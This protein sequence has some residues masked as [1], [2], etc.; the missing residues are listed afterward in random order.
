M[1]PSQR[2]PL[3][4]DAKGSSY[5]CPPYKGKSSG[6]R[7]KDISK[8]SSNSGK[9]YLSRGKTYGESISVNGTYMSKPVRKS[10]R[11]PKRRVLD[12]GFNDG[13][14]DE[15]EEIRYLGRLNASSVTAD[16]ENSGD[17]I[18][19]TGEGIYEDKDYMEEEEPTSDDEPGS[20]R[21]KTWKDSVDLFLEGRN[22]STPTTRHRTLQSSKD[23]LSGC[24]TGLLEFPDGLP[25]AQP[26]KQKEKLSELE[27]QLKKAEAAQRRRMQ[28]EKAAREAEAEAI[29]KILGQDSGRKKRE[30][31]M[32][33]QQN[34][35]TQG[36]D[37]S[38]TLAPNTIRCVIG[39]TGT[40]VTFS[41]DI[42]LPNLFSSLSG[43]YPPPREKCAGP[44]CTN[45]YKYRDSK[46]KLP[47]CSLRCYK[48]I[49]GKMQALIAC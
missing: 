25:P 31:K 22:E 26:K 47:L 32:K 5:C 14:D 21:K 20:K 19:K 1:P 18:S 17:E 7:W 37:K 46:S 43:R 6:V 49:H 38:H 10:K 29:R 41:E 27:Q 39:P 44:N 15:D 33:K 48:A 4:Q 2:K 13:D 36:K 40:T 8:P 3:Y 24:F 16:Y 35:L 42:G 9:G 34:E 28:S 30:E 45:T 11:V 12:V 23:V